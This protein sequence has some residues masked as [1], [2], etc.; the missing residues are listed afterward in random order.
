MI[1]D[2]ETVADH[3]CLLTYRVIYRSSRQS[4]SRHQLRCRDSERCFRSS[5][6][7]AGVGLL[8]GCRFDGRSAPPWFGAKNVC[9]TWLDRVQCLPPNP[10]RAARTGE[11]LV[12]G[13]CCLNRRIETVLPS[14]SSV[15]DIG[16]SPVVS[17]RSVRTAPADPSSSDGSWLGPSRSR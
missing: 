12:D 16:R 6:V 17:G 7:P 3:V 4:R 10:E 1:G 13:R 14:W 8:A 9:R 2:A 5:N 11:W 15:S